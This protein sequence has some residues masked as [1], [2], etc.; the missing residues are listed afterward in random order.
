M[1]HYTSNLFFQTE[2]EKAVKKRILKNKQEVG[3]CILPNCNV[4]NPQ[5]FFKFPKEQQKRDYWLQLCSLNMIKEEDR[6]C[7]GHFAESDFCLE[8]KRSAHP[9]LNLKLCESEVNLIVPIKGKVVVKCI[10]QDLV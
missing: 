9:S 10:H 3:T 6:I 8:L 4:K 2:I 1:N 5:T 7:A